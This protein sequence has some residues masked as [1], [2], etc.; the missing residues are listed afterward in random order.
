MMDELKPCPFCGSNTLELDKEISPTGD[1][2]IWFVTCY[3]CPCQGVR[4]DTRE[5]AIKAWNTRQDVLTPKQ[6]RKLL[7]YGECTH[8]KTEIVGPAM[9]RF[10]KQQQSSDSEE[11][12]KPTIC[13]HCGLLCSCG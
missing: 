3:D 6:E 8:C 5:E 11:G 12:E 2:S 9:S 10:N 13:P 1:Y 4:G 7:L